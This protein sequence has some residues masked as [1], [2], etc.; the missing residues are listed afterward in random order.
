MLQDGGF[1][2]GPWHA[3]LDEQRAG[4]DRRHVPVEAAFH[5]AAPEP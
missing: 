5:A 4:H 1:S 2:F 3:E